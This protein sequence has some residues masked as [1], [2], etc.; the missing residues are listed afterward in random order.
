MIRK[1]LPVTVSKTWEDPDG[2]YVFVK[3]RIGNT[4]L[5][6][7]SVYAP[8]GAKKSF[9]LQLNRILSEIG[10][11]QNLL[12]GDWNLVRDPVLDKTGPLDKNNAADRALMSDII[13]D[14]GLIDHW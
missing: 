10:A 13:E 14:H 11:S 3:L 5:C 1:S 12:G 6:I 2:R 7:G 8:T 9:L 4:H